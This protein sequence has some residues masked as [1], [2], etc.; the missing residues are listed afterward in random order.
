MLWQ[1]HH[2]LSLALAEVLPGFFLQTGM[3]S[4]RDIGEHCLLRHV[5]QGLQIALS[6][7]TQFNFQVRKLE[8]FQVA[9]FDEQLSSSG[10]DSCC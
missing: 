1:V 6:A 4:H 5:G 9:R 10:Y 3:T 8:L 7:T 2:I